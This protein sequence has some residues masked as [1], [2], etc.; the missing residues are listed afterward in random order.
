MDL[1]DKA[2]ALWLPKGSIRALLAIA[3]AGGYMAGVV[4]PEV[5]TLITGF[6]FGQKVN[7]H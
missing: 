7:G 6:Y 1:L 4:E 3:A 5:M 2:N